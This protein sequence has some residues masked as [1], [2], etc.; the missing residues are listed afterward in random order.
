[1]IPSTSTEESSAVDGA[2]ALSRERAAR[3]E[4]RRVRPAR[5]CRAQESDTA[6]PRTL[7][8][9]DGVSVVTPVSISAR[10]KRS[11]YDHF[12]PLKPC[13]NIAEV[14]QN[15]VRMPMEAEIGIPKGNLARAGSIVASSGHP[16]GLPATG[17]SVSDLSVRRGTTV[18][19]SDRS[20]CPFPTSSPRT[21]FGSE[22]F[23]KH[24]IT[25]LSGDG[26]AET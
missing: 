4:A 19:R 23:A 20:H 11:Q 21:D 10:S 15:L 18:G 16:A 2:S 9:C 13:R 5:A 12:F 26:N 7:S 6:P 1:M 14:R 24:C 25:T 22:E 3:G 17:A 8:S